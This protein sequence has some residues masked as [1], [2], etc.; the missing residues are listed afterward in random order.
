MVI[1]FFTGETESVDLLRG[2]LPGLQHS[3]L[4]NQAP[5]CT[6]TLIREAD[7][8]RLGRA[9]KKGPLNRRRRP[10]YH[11]SARAVS[12]FFLEA[13]SYDDTRGCA[14]GST[15]AWAGARWAAGGLGGGERR[16]L[17]NI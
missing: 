3:S 12:D 10:G 17:D 5:L 14:A 11:G 1:F 9:P 4:E 6:G 13:S 16:G 7:P 8:G 15:K 2:R